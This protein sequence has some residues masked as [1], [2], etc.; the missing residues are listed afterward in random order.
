MSEG[1]QRAPEARWTTDRATVL[2]V[3]GQLSFVLLLSLSIALHPGYVLNRN[4][5][6]VSNYGVHLRSAVPYSLAF[7]LCALCS[8]GAARLHR[9]GEGGSRKLRQLL[10]A[11]ACLMLLTLASTYVYKINHGFKEVHDVIGAS[12]I[13]FEL[14]ASVSMWTILRRRWDACFLAVELAGSAVVL[15]TVID[16]VHLLFVGQALSSIGF[17][18]LLIHTGLRTPS[19]PARRS[20]RRGPRS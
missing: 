8:L 12:T 16:V 10:E 3:T 15:L 2:I 11:Y 6:G 4:E 7:G 17:A 1:S 13:I 19:P 18:L 9:R 5:G 20:G 14:V